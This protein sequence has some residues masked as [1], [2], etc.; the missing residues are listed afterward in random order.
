MQAPKVIST[1]V[2]TKHLE[3]KIRTCLILILNE[4]FAQET[5]TLQCFPF[6]LLYLLTIIIYVADSKCENFIPNSLSNM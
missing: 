1:V 4:E 5:E 6:Q 3:L 2:K